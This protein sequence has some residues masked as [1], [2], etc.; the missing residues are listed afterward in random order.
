MIGIRLGRWGG[1]IRMY[2]SIT[3][4][5]ASYNT[6]Q[7]QLRRNGSAI[8][9]VLTIPDNR[10]SDSSEQVISGN[11]PHDR[12]QVY[13]LEGWGSQNVSVSLRFYTDRVDTPQ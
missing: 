9:S 4:E 12:I 1:T 6:S 11:A 5:N 8:G 10:A 7:F 3:R 13:G 2:F